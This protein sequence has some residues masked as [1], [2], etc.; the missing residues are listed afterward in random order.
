MPDE[1]AIVAA[2]AELGNQDTLNYTAAAEKH[3]V[4]RTT[5]MRRHKGQSQPTAIAYLNSQGRLSTIQEE[6]L[7]G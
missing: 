6:A 2:I 1:A 5:L 4:E 3:G 7:I